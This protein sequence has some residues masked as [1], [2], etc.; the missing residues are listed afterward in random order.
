VYSIVILSKNPVNCS[1]CVM[2]IYQNEPTL[3]RQNIIVVDD[4]A[5]EQAEKNCPNVTWLAGEKPFIFARNANIGLW[6]AFDEQN[7]DASILLNDDALLET[8][9]GF[10]M[11]RNVLLKDSQLG[12]LSAATNSVGNQN[13]MKH[14]GYADKVRREP[15]ML[16]FIAVAIKRMLWA[17][18]GELDERFSGYGLD[19]DDYSLRARQAGYKLGVWDGCFVNHTT[20]KSTFRGDGG[21]D[22]RPNLELF[23]EKWGHDNH[24]RPVTA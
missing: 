11:L 9:H 1:R 17:Q 4:G 22:Y 3:P 19:D 21:G 6:H 10:T 14:H 16:C 23:K 15:R 20:L 7:A 24:G 5:R 8:K 2:A 18:I 12:I 13:Q